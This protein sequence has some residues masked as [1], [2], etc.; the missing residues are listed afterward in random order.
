MPTNAVSWYEAAQFTNWLNASTDRQAVYKFVGTP[1]TNNYT[2]A[3]WSAAEAAGGENLYRHKNRRYVLPTENEWVKA[4]YWNR[5]PRLSRL[6]FVANGA[7]VGVLA[8][9]HVFTT[10]ERKTAITFAI[11]CERRGRLPAR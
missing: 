10:K 8:T 2:L 7:D 11:L 6:S 4:A 9:M 1:G 3:T 5:T